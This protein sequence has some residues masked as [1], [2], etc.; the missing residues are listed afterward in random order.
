MHR[1]WLYLPPRGNILHSF[2]CDCH[3]IA[4]FTTPPDMTQNHL[5]FYHQ[6]SGSAYPNFLTPSEVCWMVWLWIPF[7]TG[8]FKDV[9]S[10]LLKKRMG[11]HELLRGVISSVDKK[12]VSSQSSRLCM[13]PRTVWA[14]WQEIL[15]CMKQNKS[16]FLAISTWTALPST[17]S[18]ESSS[19]Y[20]KCVGLL[21]P[22]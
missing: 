16:T 18:S 17:F 22:G 2:P 12:Y 5:T 21:L 19:D 14:S 8:R 11:H 20:K 9:N 15:Y 1:L 10:N 7:R 3:R 4:L 6:I 13:R